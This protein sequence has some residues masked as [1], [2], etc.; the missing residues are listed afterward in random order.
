[1]VGADNNLN[2]EVQ[3]FSNISVDRREK[4]EKWNKGTS[5]KAAGK[6]SMNTCQT[7]SAL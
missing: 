2:R 7:A 4:D 6:L 1:M 3:S 5:F